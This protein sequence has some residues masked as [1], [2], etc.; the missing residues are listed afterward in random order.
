MSKFCQNCGSEMQDQEVFCANCGTQND[1]AP[2]ADNKKKL[3]AIIGGAVAIVLVLVLLVPMIFGG[4][5]KAAAQKY[6]NAYYKGNVGSL[7]SLAP[8][9]YWEYVDDKLDLEVK[10]VKDDWKDDW[11]DNLEDIVEDEGFEESYGDK[12]K[13]SYKYQDKREADKDVLKA[14][15]KYLD[16]TYDIK[17]K[18]VKALYIVDFTYTYKGDKNKDVE[19]GSVYVVQIKNKWYPVTSR[20]DFLVSSIVS[21]SVD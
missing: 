11:K 9:E 15:K 19:T 2:A 18:D 12:G 20:G 3:F 6:L 5:Q 16:S 8:E 7:K 1:A 21:N 13:I 14:V 4:A 17:E 10:D